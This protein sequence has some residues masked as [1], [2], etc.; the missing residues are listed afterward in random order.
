MEPKTPIAIAGTPLTNDHERVPTVSIVSNPRA[1]LNTVNKMT[2]DL[3]FNGQLLH[4]LVFQFKR[5]GR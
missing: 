2:C 3:L 5:P 1:V 4:I